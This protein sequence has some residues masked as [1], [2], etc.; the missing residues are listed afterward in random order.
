MYFYL[1][2]RIWPDVISR[3]MPQKNR[4]KFWGSPGKSRTETLEIIRQAFGEENMSGARKVQTQRN[5]KGQVKIKVKSML[6]IFFGIKGDCSQLIRRG[7]PNSHFLMS[8]KF[9]TKDLALANDSA[10]PQTSFFTREFCRPP[11]PPHFS[12]S[13]M[14]DKSESRHLAL[15][16]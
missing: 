7:S 10:P 13:P 11:T 15:L 6:I 1:E 14:E 12:V 2:T 16:R 5:R 4:I 8:G 9:A 3:W